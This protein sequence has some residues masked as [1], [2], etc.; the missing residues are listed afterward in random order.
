[1]YQEVDYYH[2]SGPKASPGARVLETAVFAKSEVLSKM[3]LPHHDGKVAFV[4][5]KH[6][7][8]INED[9]AKPI[10]KPAESE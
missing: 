7:K 4:K 9:H 3:L 5:L 6:K 10:S 1:M 2:E 8:M